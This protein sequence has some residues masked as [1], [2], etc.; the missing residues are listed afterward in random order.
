M[1]TETR[2]AYRLQECARLLGVSPR[3]LWDWAKRGDIPC[4]W[5][6]SGRRRIALFDPRTIEEWLQSGNKGPGQY[7]TDAQPTKR[8]G[9]VSHDC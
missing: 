3:T 5:V 6:G 2:L 1:T 9:T 7:G 4:K 8:G